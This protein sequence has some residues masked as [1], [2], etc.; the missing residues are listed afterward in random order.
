MGG[1]VG[2]ALG[3]PIEFLTLNQIRAQYGLA[4]LTDYARAYGRKGALTDDTQMTLFTAEGLILS[5]L[6]DDYARGEQVVEAVYHAYLR[7]LYTQESHLKDRLFHVHGSCSMADGM[8]TT[9]PELFSHRAPGNSCLSALRSGKMGTISAPINNSKGCGGVMRIAPVGLFYK[10]ASQA[11]KSGCECAAITHGHA[12]GYLASGVQAAIIAFIMDG[13]SLADAIGAS[14]ELLKKWDHHAICSDAIEQA[15]EMHRHGEPSSE[16]VEKLGAGWVAEE[17]LAIS[18][19]CALAF[20]DDFP[21]GVLLAV[22]HSGDSDST[23][24]ITGNL[25]GALLGVKAIPTEW[26][27]ALELREVI[28]EV[29]DDLLEQSESS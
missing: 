13:E 14:V 27:K 4:G 2:D 24:A 25:L 1:A 16:T 11:F 23:G 10:D 15:L 6:R 5:N 8:L 19:Y 12:C 18:L 21:K 26:L 22:N 28:E 3:A 17:A 7:W 29:A 20:Q 9:H